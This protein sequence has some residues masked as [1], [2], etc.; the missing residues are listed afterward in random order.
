M[1]ELQKQITELLNQNKLEEALQYC[2][3]LIVATPNHIEA[4]TL[5][6]TVH[7][8]MNNR[9]LAVEVMKRAVE[10]EPENQ[11]I[12][13]SYSADLL[14]LGH[15]EEAEVALSKIKPSHTNDPYYLL[16]KGLIHYH[17]H[18]F[19][20]ASKVLVNLVSQHKSYNIARLELAYVLL[21]NGKWRAGWEAYEVRHHLPNMKPPLKNFNLPLWDGRQVDEG[22][23]LI[24][25]QEFGDCIQF[26]RYIPLVAMRCDHIVLLR[27]EAVGRLLD[28]I[29]CINQ[30]YEHGEGENVQ[31]VSSYCM[32]SSLPRLFSTMPDSVPKCHELLSVNPGLEKV[33]RE[34]IYSTAPRAKLKIGVAWSGSLD[35]SDNYLRSIPVEKIKPLL[36]ISD[37]QFFSLQVGDLAYQAE[38]LNMVDLTDKL[39]DFAETA[40]MMQTLDLIITSD[41]S[42][43]HIAATLGKPTWICLQ[44]TPDWRW[45]PS[46][47]QTVWYKT[48]RLFRQTEKR[49]W[50][51]VIE[52]VKQSL[53]E[54][55]SQNNPTAALESYA[56]HDDQKDVKLIYTKNSI[57]PLRGRMKNI[58]MDIDMANFILTGLPRSGTTVISASL[59]THADILFYGELLNNE[60]QVRKNESA[61]ITLGAG[62][63]IS[64]TPNNS[65]RPCTPEESGYQYLNHFYSLRNNLG[66]LG[67]KLLVD[68]ALE[69][70][71]RDA[72]DYVAENTNIKIIRTVRQNLL[73]IICSYV[74]A[75]ITRRW[76]IS[77]ET[78]KNPRF[79]LPIN[80]CEILFKRFSHVPDA[81]NNISDTHDVLDIEYTRI[82]TDFTGV[83]TNIFSFL[84]VNNE[85]EAKPQLSKIAQFLPNQE[86]VN[87]DELRDHFSNT[88]YGQYF[89]Y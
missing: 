80:E 17:K 6:A 52:E 45:G 46:D 28:S 10:L 56:S 34:I 71:N 16:Q 68:Q 50:E 64:N 63:K 14:K 79:V 9:V 26:S 48:A 86:I 60:I 15:I 41:T 70:P 87:Y 69:G 66:A 61:R 59:V 13:V 83:M 65:L 20:M 43:A 40:A 23:L 38:G 32:L 77:N 74:R 73:E 88:E 49:L 21:M 62:W 57:M 31:N 12:L 36:E 67:F 8:K 82:E 44:Y 81:L 25:D 5:C 30:S 85:I 3:N 89:I 18:E 22:I 37:C 47:S 42:I 24:A 1:T 27:N 7:K 76:H 4:L 33:W 58:P 39:T 55:V 72:W 11:S 78:I 29:P 75:N 51:T 2:K 53:K 84:R 19:E 54:T 35:F